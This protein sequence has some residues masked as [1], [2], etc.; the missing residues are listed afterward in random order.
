MS[1]TDVAYQDIRDGV[2]ALCAGFPPEYHRNVD[3]ERRYPEEFVN[4]LKC[5]LIFFQFSI[6][7]MI[8]R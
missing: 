5:Q 6:M 4:F 3:K 7:I 2:R 1:Y 8:C